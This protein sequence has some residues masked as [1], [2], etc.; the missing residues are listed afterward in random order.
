[1]VI[2][3]VQKLEFET[4]KR[5]FDM[6]QPLF[7]EDLPA[8]VIVQPELVV[9]TE[10]LVLLR[11]GPTRSCQSRCASLHTCIW[12]LLLGTY[13][14][15]SHKSSTVLR[16]Y[17]AEYTQPALHINMQALDGCNIQATAKQYQKRCKMAWELHPQRYSLWAAQAEQN[18]SEQELAAVQQLAQRW[19]AL[20]KGQRL[21]LGVPKP[22]EMALRDG[23]EGPVEAGIEASAAIIQEEEDDIVQVR[24]GGRDY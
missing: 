20:G 18:V 8:N 3:G 23:H 13:C 19:A 11:R 10:G 17:S 7:Q 15:L 1:M 9:L 12:I 22:A 4:H 14:M 2:D 6:L 21:D 16:T 5:H 24:Y